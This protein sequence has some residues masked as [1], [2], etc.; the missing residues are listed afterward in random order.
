MELRYVK[1]HRYRLVKDTKIETNFS[2]IY[3]AQDLE[4]NRDV[5]I[6]SV[7]IDGKNPKEIESKLQSAMLEVQT[8]VEVSGMTIYIPNIFSTYFHKE[9]STLVVL[10]LC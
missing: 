2:M 4:L 5:C 6:K 7:K 10:N 8:M 9:K 1:E 3:K